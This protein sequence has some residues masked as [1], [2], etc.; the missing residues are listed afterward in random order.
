M[1]ETIAINCPICDSLSSKR[2]T[3]RFDFGRIVQCGICGHIYL[4]PTLTDKYL[5]TIYEGYHASQD[6]EV[7][8]VRVNEWFLDPSGPYQHILNI[9]GGEPGFRGKRM[10]D[11]G[12]GPGRFA[13]E[14]QERGANIKGVDSNHNAARLAKKYFNLDIIPK[15]LKNAIED[16]DLS[17]GGFETA[18]AFETIEHVRKPAEFLKT[19]HDLLEPGGMLYISTPNFYLFNLMGRAAPAIRQCPE[20]INFFSPQSLRS[21][22]ELCGYKVLDVTTV[23]ILKYGDRKKQVF[24]N[25]PIFRILWRAARHI[26]SIYNIKNRIFDTLNEHQEGADIKSWNGTTIVCIA[27]RPVS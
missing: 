26:N 21:C 27:Q 10:L 15:P 12:C 8:M 1:P 16:G 25:M 9:I 17:A 23:N 19:L 13:Y 18:F 22:V 5:N 3:F 24:A 7:Y 20:H 2:V 4:N 6:E 14:C 11:V